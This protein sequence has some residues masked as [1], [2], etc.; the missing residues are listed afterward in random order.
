MSSL[1]GPERLLLSWHL[2][3]SGC[4]SQFPILHCYTPLFNFLTFCTFPIP[5][6]APLLP[7]PLF[8]PSPSHPLLPL[9]LLFPLLSRTETST[10]CSSFLLSFL[11]S[12]SCMWVFYSLCLKLFM[13][14]LSAMNFPLSPAFIVSHKIGYAVP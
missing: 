14:A 9:I 8:L 12:L 3:L 13:E 10:L 4:Y 11:W 5:D 7:L 2:G 6:S 1:W